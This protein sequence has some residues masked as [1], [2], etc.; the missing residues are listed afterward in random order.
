LHS[1][2]TCRK[3]YNKRYKCESDLV[4]FIQ[5]R[6]LRYTLRHGARLG[7]DS[8][9]NLHA[10]SYEVGG[11]VRQ[12]TTYPDLEVVFGMEELL[13]DM[14]VELQLQAPRQVLSYDTT[15]QLGNFY[16]SFA[17]YRATRFKG[18]PCV[19]ALFLLHE[20]K[21]AS[22]HMTFFRHLKEVIPRKCRVGIVTDRER[23][24]T[25]AISAEVPTLHQVF[26]WNHIYADV[27]NW[28]LKHGAP[29]S[30]ISIITSHLR[31][32]FNQPSQQD[33]EEKLS[34]M[35]GV[36][37]DLFREYYLQHIHKEV[38]TG[39]GRWRLEQLGLYTADSGVTTNLSESLNKVIK[40]L[41]GWKEAPVDAMMTALYQLQQ[42]FINEIQR[43]LAGE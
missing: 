42:Y 36:W 11:F 4:S 39:I 33:Y 20:R 8:L 23:A 40:A 29:I 34:E 18:E 15:F 32:L 37:D 26:C 28:L 5:I 2:R 35:S 30:D 12:I 27:R 14:K 22:T 10:L 41:Q 19:P 9:Y 38:D 24:I 16:L 6:N 25:T 31:T 17:L 3:R 7:Q 1:E 21:F 43:G 13:E